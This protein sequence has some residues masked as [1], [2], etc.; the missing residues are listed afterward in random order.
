MASIAD[1]A[2][3][4]CMFGKCQIVFYSLTG[5]LIYFFKGIDVASP[6]LLGLAPR[7]QKVVFGLSLPV[8]FISGSINS[9]TAA[10][11]FY[12]LIYPKDSPHRF[13]NTRQGLLTWAGLSFSITAV[14]A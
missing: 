13:M 5:A 12:E 4:L 10:K 8:I 11:F 7:L 6:A 1:E 2:V 14:G 3:V 9:Q